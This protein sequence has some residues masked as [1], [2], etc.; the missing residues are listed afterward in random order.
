M[1]FAVNLAQSSAQ[2]KPP[3][4]RL[5]K[6]LMSLPHLEKPSELEPIRLEPG[7]LRKASRLTLVAVA[8]A[9]AVVLGLACWLNPDERGFG[10]H[11]QLGLPPCAFRALTGIPC[12]SCGMT[13]SFAHVMRGRL[14]TAAWTNAGGCVLA[15]GLV[16][17]IPWCLAS[18]A[19]GRTI[20][21]RSPERAAV[22]IVL[23]VV[24]I[25]MIGWTI[26]FFL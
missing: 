7:P 24:A 3:C 26:R 12:P 19:V 22:V 23:S 20:G 17:L 4:L 10:T 11:E 5:L 16:G 13:T 8:A 2:S 1:T 6:E 9:L 14:L 18:A 15:L 25:T 21:V